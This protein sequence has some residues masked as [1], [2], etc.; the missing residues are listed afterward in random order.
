MSPHPRHGI[1]RPDGSLPL[2]IPA[3]L[4]R[5]GASGRLRAQ[6]TGLMETIEARCT[7]LHAS[8]WLIGSDA[9]RYAVRD[10]PVVH[11]S[12]PCCST[13][14]RG[15]TGVLH[16]A[17]A[18][19][20]SEAR[21][22]SDDELALIESVAWLAGLLVENANAGEYRALLDRVPSIMYIADPGVHG[23]WHYVNAQVKTI[24][25]F[26]QEEWRRDPTLWARQ[27]HPADRERVLSSEPSNE[28]D[29]VVDPKASE[30]RMLHRDGRTVWVRDDALLMQ[31]DVGRRRWHGILLDIT[32][33][34]LT[35]FELERRAAQQATVARLGE[36]ALE[37]VATAALLQEAVDG[38]REVL[39]VDG[40]VVAQ[41][42]PD[43]RSFEFRAACGVPEVAIGHESAEDGTR[44]QSLYT[45]LTGAPVVVADWASEGRFD[46]PEAIISQGIR[47]S[48]TVAI[49]GREMPFGI[50]GVHA[51]APHAYSSGDIDFVQSLANVLA[52]ALERKS[53]EDAIEHR[54]LHDA[55]TG[56]PNRVLFLDRLEQALERLRRRPGTRAAVLFIDLDNFKLVNDSFGHHAGDELLSAVAARLKQAVRP[57]DTVARFSG[58][59]F[60]LLLEEISSER[61]AIAMAERIGSVFAR[62][63]ALVRNAE[64]FVTTSVGIALAESGDLPQDLIS[65]A[66]AAMYRAKERGRARYE[67]FDE[68]MRGRAIARLRIENDL[69]R[70]I[71][72]DELRLAYQP[73]VSLCDESIACV[74]A[75]LRW[76]HP[77]RGAI[78][79][80]EFVRV[81]EESGLIERIG[82][83]VLERACRQAAEWDKLRPD[84]APLGIAVNLSPL[85]LSHDDFPRVVAEVLSRSGLDPSRLSLEITETLLLGEAKPISEVLRTLKRIGVRL[86]LDDFGIGYSS[87]GYLSR[88]PLDA[89]KVDRSFVAALGSD[90]SDSAITEAIIAMARALS[91]E[92]VGEGAE[93]AAQVAELKRLGCEFVQGYIFSEPLPAA[94]IA[95]LLSAAARVPGIAGG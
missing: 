65:D 74:E 15:S 43:R 47:S 50:L 41:L 64:H 56:L 73:I 61:E 87:L 6:L 1:D 88:L 28:L 34:K 33:R 14:I 80:S 24:L 54:A 27:L 46:K 72:R 76:D 81:A 62:P 57:T 19:F 92:V 37:R 7:G 75:L 35:E 53:T 39:M 29:G 78:P 18:M 9:R 82:R 23:R 4:L 52:D 94:E 67:L 58:D 71:E 60:G 68:V 83:W 42:L 89:L 30:Y 91:L 66:D 21:G 95:A 45:V 13:A 20:A 16:G 8:L 26:S 85:Q 86:V 17:I 55:L 84:A 12:H 36:H 49:E 22:P 31:D 59:E 11:L 5:A 2:P 44:S 90:S 77:E 32:D 93:T 69:R 70:A 51:S 38:A 79:P 10:P 63:F 3:G 40:A 48:L 25:G